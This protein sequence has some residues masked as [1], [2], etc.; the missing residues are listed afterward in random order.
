MQKSNNKW[1]EGPKKWAIRSV[2][3]GP[4]TEYPTRTMARAAAKHRSRFDDCAYEVLRRDKMPNG[5]WHCVETH[6]FHKHL[7]NAMQ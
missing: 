2:N 3:G 6:D 5:I 4:F 7:R 1:I